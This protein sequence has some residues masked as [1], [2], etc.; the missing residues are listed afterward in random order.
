[1]AVAKKSQTTAV[2][3]SGTGSTNVNLPSSPA[4]AEGDF[5]CVFLATDD[6]IVNS[7]NGVLTSGY[8]LA[9]NTGGNGPGGQ[10]AHKFMGVTPDSVV[11]IGQ[12][13]GR[14]IAVIIRVYTGVDTSTPIDNS[15]TPNSDG[16][17]PNPSSHTT[18]TDGALRIAAGFL[19]DDDVAANV[20]GISGWEDPLAADTGGGSSTAGATI[21]V[22]SLAAPTAGALDPAEFSHSSGFDESAAIH[23]ALRPAAGGGSDTITA[24]IGSY[25]V[26]GNAADTLYDRVMSA[27]AGSYSISGLAAATGQGF[28]SPV[29]AGSY[30]LTGNAAVLTRDHVM[31][32]VAGSYA[33]TGLDATT[34]AG[35]GVFDTGWIIAGDGATDASY[36]DGAWTDPGNIVAE[37][38][39]E[40]R[41]SLTV[42][43]S[44]ETSN[45]LKSS[46]HGLAVPAGSAIIGIEVRVK[47]RKVA[48]SAG[49]LTY[50]RVRVVKAGSVGSDEGSSG[51]TIP[52]GSYT[53]TDFG[54]ST[55]LW[56]DTWTA[57]DV[58]GS[59]F[60][61]AVAYTVTGSAGNAANAGV[62]AVWVK[63]YYSAGIALIANPG[64]YV[65]SGLAAQ[66][67]YNPH[68]VAGLGSYSYTGQDVA[69]LRDEV[70]TAEQGS[71]TY[72]GLDATTTQG[73]EELTAEPGS[74]VLTGNDAETRFFEV[75]ASLGTY[76]ITGL[77]AVTLK[78]YVMPAALGSYAVTGNAIDTS[79]NFVFAVP[80]GSY[81][82]TGL[83]AT[84]EAPI[85]QNHPINP[86]ETWTDTPTDPVDTW[87]DDTPGPGETWN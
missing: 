38:G 7:T 85:W 10:F 15:I 76:T 50:D 28:S 22:D 63:V 36:G 79:L 3:S 31:P 13:N 44:V 33:V 23:F 12:I 65:I 69:F 32:A 81:V 18:V 72:T 68:L 17:F 59:G 49:T 45:Y 27:E 61:A 34:S 60:G 2:V 56:S 80:L 75:L 4:L 82:L 78:G 57:A 84:F 20:T 64:S 30:T 16:N 11:N 8:T 35:A 74:Y 6:T 41:R 39:S 87:Y 54:G 52:A 83:A 40:A 66:T 62:D 73:Q 21:M 67:G 14:A 53:T 24:D 70:L 47:A 42:A 58:N 51:E 46:S 9:Y 37:D 29:E 86:G 1:M 43:G 25:T 26:T 71:Y 48:A 55:D 5:V 77:D 19:D